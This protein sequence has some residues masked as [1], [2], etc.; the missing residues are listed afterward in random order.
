MKQ[1]TILVTLLSFFQLKAQLEYPRF[2][3][4][5]LCS[6]EFHGRGYVNGGDSIAA[7]FIASQFKELGLKSFKRSYFQTYDF[8][9]N[10]FPGEV[11]MQRDVK[12][13]TPGIH[14]LIDPASPS[15]T[16]TLKPKI[17]SLS[18][19]L[20][21]EVLIKEI[22]AIKS[23]NYFNAIAYSLKGVSADTLK[24]LR[25]FSSQLAQV[26]PV[27][28]VTDKKFTWSVAQEQFPFPVIQ[29]QDSV[30][31]KSAI[32]P[33]H[34]QAKLLEKHQAK[35][36]IGYFPGK[37][38]AKTIVFSAHYDHLGQMGK[39]AYFPGA[40]DNASGVAMLLSLAKYFKEHPV[41][42]TIVFM[43]FSGEEAGLI[44]SNYFTKHPLFKLKNIHFLVN[45]DIMGSGEDGV[46]VVNATKFEQQFKQL[47]SINTEK[48]YLKQVKSRGPA[49]NSDHY[50]F[51]EK[52]VPAFFIYTMGTN[53]NYH[54]VFDTYENLSFLAF[55]NL[56]QLLID[57]IQI[58]E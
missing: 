12:P 48:G 23:A 54:D 30:F 4:K 3:A 9:V 38:G 56:Q 49:A 8:K 24:L 53:S 6:P 2:V 51:T 22:Q 41:D 55:V 5:T 52:G 35:N 17:I 7:A 10:S 13:L 11:K 14:F 31:S 25:G 27:I 40:N 43:A 32:Y 1:L 50:W 58:V 19:A 57:F 39:D 15:A 47:S 45:L 46:T 20:N 26:L 44:G 28:E 21:K 33:I 37:K 42:Y 18:T 34:I 36:V 29:I 16:S